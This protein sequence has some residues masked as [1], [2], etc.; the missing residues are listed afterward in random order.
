VPHPKLKSG[1]STDNNSQKQFFIATDSE[2]MEQFA[3]RVLDFTNLVLFRTSSE[4]TEHTL[5]E[6]CLI[7]LTL[8]YFRAKI[9]C[10]L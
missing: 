8:Q 5:V 4:N 6:Q 3:I 9:L 10:V 2:S 7:L 1:C